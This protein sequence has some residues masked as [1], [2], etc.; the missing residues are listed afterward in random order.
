MP[1]LKPCPHCGR[2]VGDWHREWYT[3]EQQKLLFKHMAAAD[4]PHEDCEGAVDLY[5]DKDEIPAADP[6]LEIIHR[7]RKQAILWAKGEAYFEFYLQN[8]TAVKQYADYSFAP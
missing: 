3:Q 8:V 5:S 6:S 7:S 4:C 2:L 1:T